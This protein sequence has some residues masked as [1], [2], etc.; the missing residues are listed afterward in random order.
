MVLTSHGFLADDACFGCWTYLGNTWL[1]SFSPKICS[2]WL[3]C[4]RWSAASLITLHKTAGNI[5]MIY[6]R[7]Q[8]SFLLEG[9]CYLEH[10]DPPTVVHLLVNDFCQIVFLIINKKESHDS[11]KMWLRQFL[12]YF[13]YSF[14]Y[15]FF[16][17]YF[18]VQRTGTFKPF[19]ITY[20][21]G[22]SF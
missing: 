10:Q 5:K 12:F 19:S 9:A 4:D 17:C 15:I 1:R 13:L 14:L 7:I 11:K 8:V 2:I 20:G 18:S 22:V 16:S 21:L 6:G 3:A